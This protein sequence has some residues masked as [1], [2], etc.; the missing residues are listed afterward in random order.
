MSENGIPPLF[1]S[2]SYCLSFRNSVARDIPRAFA[3]LV[4]LPLYLLRVCKISSFS[5]ECK[6]ETGVAVGLTEDICGAVSE[7]YILLLTTFFR[8]FSSTTVPGQ[9]ITILSMIFESSRTL[10]LRGR[11][12]SLCIT[13]GSIVKLP[14]S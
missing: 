4:L 6:S 11:A 5:F 12:C 2:A 7:A 10:P 9:S 3:V 13:E 14:F 1:Q 8:R